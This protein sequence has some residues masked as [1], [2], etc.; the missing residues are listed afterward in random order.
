MANGSLD[1]K[2]EWRRGD[3]GAFEK[4]SEIG[5]GHWTVGDGVE[6]T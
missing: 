2:L 1:S 5:N 6:K 3:G 4:I